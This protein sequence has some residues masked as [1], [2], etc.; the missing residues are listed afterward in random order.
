V[1]ATVRPWR[2]CSGAAGLAGRDE[3]PYL[4]VVRPWN[5]PYWP[6]WTVARVLRI[7]VAVFLL[8]AFIEIARTTPYLG[9]PFEPKPKDC[10]PQAKWNGRVYV[11]TGRTICLGD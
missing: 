5:G 9:L 4:L 11:P 3:A 6:K 1:V 2:G 7:A 8:A 10:Y